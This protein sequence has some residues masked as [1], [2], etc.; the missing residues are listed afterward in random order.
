LL[1]GQKVLDVHEENVCVSGDGPDI[2]LKW[3]DFGFWKLCSNRKETKSI[4]YE[5]VFELCLNEY[6][7]AKG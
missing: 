4:V 7:D 5:N 6:W 1:L 2:H 3:I